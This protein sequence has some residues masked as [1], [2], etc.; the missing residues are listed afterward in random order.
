MRRS[1]ALAGAAVIASL[2]VAQAAVAKHP[3]DVNYTVAESSAY[4]LDKNSKENVRLE[5]RACVAAGQPQTIR[6]QIVAN[7]NRQEAGDAPLSMLSRRGQPPT[8]SFTPASVVLDGD[9]GT[10]QVF[11][12]TA[13]F[14]LNLVVSTESEFVLGLRFEPGDPESDEGIRVKV[15]CVVE[16]PP[17]AGPPGSQGTIL[18]ESQVAGAI[19]ASPCRDSRFG[20]AAAI[21]GTNAIDRITGTNGSDRIF[22]F[23]GD[24]RVSGGRGNDCLDGGTGG[25]R[26][27]GGIGNDLL[28]GGSGRDLLFGGPG[29]DRLRGGGGRDFINTG[30]GSDIVVAGTGNDV[31]N[32]ATAGRPALVDCGPGRD[33]VRINGNEIGRTRRCER[34][35]VARG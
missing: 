34:V 7:P 18:S 1:L 14:T 19:A 22:T 31:I 30:N 10:Q 25:D 35:I 15:P 9:K 11:D 29:R 23:G 20:R 13:T 27:D 8:V 32:A 12:V 21:V 28:I 24:D 2:A 26:L 33:T 4:T 3:N 17:S 5:Y 16:A 6:F